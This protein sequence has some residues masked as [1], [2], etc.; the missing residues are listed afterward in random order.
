MLLV[1]WAAE[2][3]VQAPVTGV[4]LFP[5]ELLMKCEQTLLLEPT[6]AELAQ[7]RLA[8]DIYRAVLIVAEPV[9]LRAV[10]IQV[11]LS[12]EHVIASA[13]PVPRELNNT[14]SFGR[15]R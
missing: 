1:G 6:P 14:E 4:G 2:E 9:L 7:K 11:R 13:A 3:N 5:V 12:S 15:F 8:L 10:N